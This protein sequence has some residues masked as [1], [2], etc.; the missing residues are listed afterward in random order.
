MLTAAQCFVLP[1][2]ALLILD[3]IFDQ[4]LGLLYS[5]RRFFE[6]L[7]KVFLVMAQCQAVSL[8]GEEYF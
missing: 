5:L 4:L 8:V 3:E 6:E 1:K 7:R 2:D